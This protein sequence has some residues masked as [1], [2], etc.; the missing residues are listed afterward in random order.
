MNN[1]ATSQ[2]MQKST[3]YAFGKMKNVFK[4]PLFWVAFLS[5]VLF[6]I[7]MN[8]M[9]GLK[10]EPDL[11]FMTEKR[12][13]KIVKIKEREPDELQEQD[14][15]E[16]EYEEEIESQEDKIIRHDNENIEI[17]FDQ[18]GNID[19]SKEKFCC[20]ILSEIYNI[21]FE[22]HRPSWLKNPYT[23]KPLELDCYNYEYGVA[24]EYNG[25]QHYKFP[26]PFHKTEQEFIMQKQRDI[27]KKYMCESKGILLIEVPY[28]IPV[29][30]LKKYIENKILEKIKKEKMYNNE[31]YIEDV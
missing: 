10:Y 17:D 25:I 13:K 21:K 8:N 12:K 11:K 18:V 15:Y 3:S 23:N 30:N 29:E 31:E 2:V 20:K 4:S 27:A 26:N 22:K 19:F 9:R 1:I 28:Y 5:F 6:I 7:V 24:L 14:D 16:Q